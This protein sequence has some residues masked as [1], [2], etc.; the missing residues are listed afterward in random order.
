MAK[1][2]KLPW[3]AH[4]EHVNQFAGAN[5]LCYPPSFF[6][7]AAANINLFHLKMQHKNLPK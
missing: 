6:I 5:L 3:S 2:S 7:D 4:N 1:P